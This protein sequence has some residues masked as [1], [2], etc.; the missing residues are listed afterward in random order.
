IDP[1]AGS[2]R[3]IVLDQLDWVEQQL[4][5]AAAL[6]QFSACLQ[7]EQLSLHSACAMFAATFA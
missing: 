2:E 5:D 6:R 4:G 3:L 7:Q 1:Q